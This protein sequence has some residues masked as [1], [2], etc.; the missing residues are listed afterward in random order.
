MKGFVA[1]FV[2]TAVALWVA[3]RYV[4]GIEI[5]S[6]GF[7]TV[8]DDLITFGTVAVVFGVANGLI[9]SVVRALTL[10]FNLFTMGLAGF[11]VNVILFLGAAYISNELGGRITVGDYPPELLTQATLVAAALGSLVVGL[12]SAVAQL[13]IPD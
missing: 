12:V 4:P 9:G 3:A 6:S 8:P 5:P 13:V 11:I 7:A 2:A 1:T 10:P